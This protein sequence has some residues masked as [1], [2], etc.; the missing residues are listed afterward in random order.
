ML[1]SRM[2]SW[3]VTTWDTPPGPTYAGAKERRPRPTFPMISA[4]SHPTK[5]GTAIFRKSAQ[6]TKKVKITCRNSEVLNGYFGLEL[7]DAERSGAGAR[8]ALG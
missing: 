8:L 2:E 5:T 4:S 3:T 7:E 1:C 6:G